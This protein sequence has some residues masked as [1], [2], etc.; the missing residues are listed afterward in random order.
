MVRIPAVSMT[1]V[2][3]VFILSCG[4]SQEEAAPGEGWQVDI[5]WLADSFPEL[6]YDPFMYEPEDSLQSR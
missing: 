1:S 2:L 5:Q 4:E 3:V 6:H